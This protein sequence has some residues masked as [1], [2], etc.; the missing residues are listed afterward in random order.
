MGIDSKIQ[1]TKHTF[2]CW[3]GCIKVSPACT[4]CYAE[5][6]AKRTGN[7][8][9]GVDSR[10]KFM[11]DKYWKQPPRWNRAAEKAGERHRVFCGSM[12]DV[13]EILPRE[14]PDYDAMYEARR[15]LWSM[16]EETEHLDWLLL[17]K[18]PQ[19]IRKLAPSLW[20]QQGFPPNVWLGTTVENQEWADK[21]VPE[22]ISLPAAVR[23][24][25]CEPL[26]D[27]I[28]LRKWLTDI[29]WVIVGGESGPKSREFPLVLA[30]HL[31]NQCKGTEAAFFMKQLGAKPS[32]DGELIKLANKKGGDIDEW[33]LWAQ[34][35][36]F[37]QPRMVAV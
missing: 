7:D 31:M 20:V 22:L 3:W 36:Q 14:H 32:S 37:P 26:L 21:R 5:A 13:F 25:S 6:W 11:G 24:L 35:R 8:V 34:V 33:P 1:W 29:D 27:A 23:F 28:N 30:H 18:R 4:N 17:T 16:I 9:W 2:N 19:N 10:R 15:K 12:C